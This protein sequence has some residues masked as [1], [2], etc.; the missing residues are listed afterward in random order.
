LSAALVLPSVAGYPFDVSP[1]LSKAAT[2]Q[3]LSPAAIKGFLR[4]MDKWGVKDP[5]ARQLLGGI[6]SGS[7]Y[8]WKKQP[9]R[10]LDQD[11]LIRISLLLGIFKALNILYGEALADAWITLPNSNPMFR[12]QSPLAYMIERGQPGML[13]LRQLLDARRGG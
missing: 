8:S 4:I 5:D 10:V 1:D 7:Y 11:T 3:R 2:R 12:G 13:H 9:K 6:S